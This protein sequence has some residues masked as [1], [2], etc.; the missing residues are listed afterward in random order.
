MATIW[1]QEGSDARSTLATHRSYGR[2]YIAESAIWNLSNH[3]DACYS[4]FIGH[5]KIKVTT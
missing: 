3:V 1:D 2:E 4:G 5:V